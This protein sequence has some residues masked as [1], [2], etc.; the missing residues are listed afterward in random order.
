MSSSPPPVDVSPSSSTRQHAGATSK[1]K[2]KPTLELYRVPQ[3]NQ[4]QQRSRGGGAA[5]SPARA[6]FSAAAAH[7]SEPDT[8]AAAADTA[9]ISS[10]SSPLRGGITPVRGGAGPPRGRGGG[11]AA[12]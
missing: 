11:A 9:D 6:E 12:P 2:A 1:P 3:R 4:A 10:V 8:A 5:L 7:L